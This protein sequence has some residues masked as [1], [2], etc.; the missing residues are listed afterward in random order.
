MCTGGGGGDGGAAQARADE[1]AR[2]A[3]IKEG[4][5]NIDKNFGGFNEAFYNQRAKA[6]TD[7]A[8]PQLA[9]QYAQ[10]QRNLTYNLARQGLTASSEAARNAGELQRQYNDN[11]AQIA[12]QGLDAANQARGQVEQNRSELL[13][14]LNATSDPAAAAASAVNRAGI[15]SQQ[16]SFSPLGQLFANTT[17]LLGNAAMAGY[18]DRNAPGLTPYKQIFGGGNKE[19]VYK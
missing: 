15:L 17:G 4:S 2:Q 8:N 12:A 3:R 7:Y 1:A 18:Y 9:D 13:A 19:K 14:Q 11:R 10:T 5:A 16:S 6:Y